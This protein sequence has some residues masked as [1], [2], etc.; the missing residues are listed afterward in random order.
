MTV[1]FEVNDDF[2]MKREQIHNNVMNKK[3]DN[4]VL[5][6]MMIKKVHENKVLEI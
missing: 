5:N 2:V 3:H 1:K 4:N 6:L